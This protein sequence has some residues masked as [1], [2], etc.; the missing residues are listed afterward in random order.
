[1][2][3]QAHD[4]H[5][6]PLAL[7][8][9]VQVDLTVPPTPPVLEARTKHATQALRWLGLETITYSVPGEPDARVYEG[10]YRRQHGIPPHEQNA[11]EHG[12]L[13]ATDILAV[14]KSAT[15]PELANQLV[16]VL[17]YRPPVNAYTL[18]LPSGCI[19]RGETSPENTAVREL[20]EETGFTGTNWTVDTMYAYEPSVM[21][22]CGLLVR[23]EVDLDAPENV[24]ARPQLEDDEF[25]LTTMLIP[26]DG[27]YHRLKAFADQHDNVILDSRLAAFAYGLQFAKMVQ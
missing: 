1:M 27:L 18:E 6:H 20:K 2:A 22:A 7:P 21:G 10:V 14:T 5:P 13:D 12:T 17:Q 4:E 15:R 9:H 16:A 8:P 23:C 26:L 25:S 11:P 24:H 3:D 19:D